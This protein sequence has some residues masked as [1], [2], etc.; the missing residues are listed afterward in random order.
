MNKEFMIRYKE[1]LEKQLNEG[2]DILSNL[3]VMH[4]NYKDVVVNINNANNI[5]LQLETEIKKLD[6]ETNK[7]KVEETVSE[8]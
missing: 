5:A 8:E 4:E 7:E 1:I 2:L 6:E 3:T